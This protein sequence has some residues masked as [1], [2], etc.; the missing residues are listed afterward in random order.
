MLRWAFLA[1]FLAITGATAPAAAADNGSLPG[2]WPQW[3]G[4]HRDD[5]SSDT[6]LLKKWPKEG[7]RLVWETK[8]AGRGYA[9]VAIANGRIYTMGDG[10]SIADDKDEYVVCFDESSG[11]P[12]WKA[13]LGPPWNSGQPNWHSS[14]STP[15]VAGELLFALTPAGDLVCLDTAMGKEHWRKNLKTDFGGQKGDPWGYSESVLVDGDKVVCTPGGE[16]N[17]MVALDK[18]T[19]ATVWTASV[20]KNP[21]A[22]HASIVVA[23]VGPTRVYVQTTAGGALGVRAS[24]GKVLWTYP[25]ARTTA[26]IPTPIVDGD[27]VF[28]SVGYN[29]GGALLRQLPAAAAEVKIK[30]VYPLKPA[31][32]NKHGGIVHVGDFLYGDTNDAG[33]PFCAEFKTGRVRWKQRGSGSGSAAPTYADGHLYIRYADGKMVLALA[34]PKA[35]QEISSFK[36]PHSGARPSWSH[37]VVA[38]GRLYLREGDYLLCYDVRQQ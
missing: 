14:R 23:E 35:Y 21:G 27:L 20:A 11:A 4:P 13:R 7:P 10:L 38:G 31:L 22:G 9:S 24:D 32:N 16:K 3:R 29:R 33:T 6:G 18:T 17:T 34:S 26:V 12:V 2:E 36:I 28:F 1:G 25:I 30:E 8:G 37:P 15:T 19:G 5:L